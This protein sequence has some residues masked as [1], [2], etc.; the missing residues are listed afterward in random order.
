[1]AIKTQG[2]E[3]YFIDP[4]DDTVMEVG[5]IT[6]FTGLDAT[7]A[8]I[9]TT[10]LSAEA[11][12]YVAGMPTPGTATFGINFDPSDASHVGLHELYKTGTSLTWVLGLGDGTDSPSV[13]SEGDPVLPV[14]RTFIT[15]GGY[16]SSFPFDLALNSVVTNS[17]GVQISGF[18][19]LAPKA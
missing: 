19:N 7:L 17:I 1:M 18:P 14:T 13:D 16:I 5:C 4:S 11:H 3:L 15:F 12:T 10:C 8:Q 9:E 6:S 2:T